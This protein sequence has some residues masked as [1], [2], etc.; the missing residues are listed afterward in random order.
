MNKL[1]HLY[2]IVSSSLFTIRIQEVL[3]QFKQYLLCENKNT[4]YN[5]VMKPQPSQ[6]AAL[7]T[8]SFMT[9]VTTEKLDKQVL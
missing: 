6:A 2:D 3:H 1:S 4:K 9:D 5:C 7:D 8:M